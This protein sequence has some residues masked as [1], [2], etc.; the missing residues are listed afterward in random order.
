VNTFPKLYEFPPPKGEDAISGGTGKYAG[1]RGELRYETRGNKSIVI[2][3]F[4]G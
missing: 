3:R 2:F 4:I 1:V